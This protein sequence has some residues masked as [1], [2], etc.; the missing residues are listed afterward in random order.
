MGFRTKREPIV[1][2][3]VA[4]SNIT[5]H[6][7]DWH[8]H[9]PE[10]TCTHPTTLVRESGIHIRLVQYTLQLSYG[11]VAYIHPNDSYASDCMGVYKW[12]ERAYNQPLLRARSTNQHAGWRA[13]YTDLIPV[14]CPRHKVFGSG[15]LPGIADVVHG[16]RTVRCV[17]VGVR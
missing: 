11:R 15:M 14:V 16:P 1:I 12:G 13:A 3:I 8:T 9:H 7:R 6:T 10:A 2:L 17:W 4:Y 5:L